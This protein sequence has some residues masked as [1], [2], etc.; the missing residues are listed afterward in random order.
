MARILLVDDEPDLLQT[1]GVLLRSEG[2][3]V[4]AVRDGLEAIKR[5][6][7]VEQFD[8]LLTDLRMAP[9]DGLELI[10]TANKERPNMDIIVVSAYLD[11]EMVGQVMALGATAYI[12]KPF[13]LEDIL[14]PVREVLL[15]RTRS[16]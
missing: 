15:R 3:S 4:T 6:Q 16:G 10:E 5:L 1:V 14:G 2:H 12:D 9:V 13:S 11:D 8:L 7:S